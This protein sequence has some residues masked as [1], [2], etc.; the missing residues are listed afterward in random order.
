MLGEKAKKKK[1]KRMGMGMGEREK[2]NK[3]QRV[4][5]F[6]GRALTIFYN[7]NAQV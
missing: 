3:K 6:L 1:K 4:F 5:N 7:A 2:E